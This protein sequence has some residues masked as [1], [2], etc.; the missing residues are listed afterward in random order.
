[1]I[2]CDFSPPWVFALLIFDRNDDFYTLKFFLCFDSL[3]LKLSIVLQL[4]RCLFPQNEQPSS[5]E[6]KHRVSQKYRKNHVT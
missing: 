4:T 2:C 5:R 6:E 3:F 1:M